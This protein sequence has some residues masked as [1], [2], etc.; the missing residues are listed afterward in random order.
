MNTELENVMDT[1]WSSSLER[2]MKKDIAPIRPLLGDFIDVY[3]PQIRTLLSMQ[4]NPAIAKVI[5]DTA[6]ASANRN[7]F[8]IMKKLGMPAD[9]FWKFEYWPRERAYE[10][11]RKV[12]NKVFWTM[13]NH[14]KEGGLELTAVE[15]E[16]VRFTIA[17]K[18]CAD[19]PA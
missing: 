18:D 7:T 6:Y 10:T 11:L 16:P 2:M 12:I 9:Y 15:I 3:V 19:P 17:F 8:V 14:N 5:Y 13:M 4:A 1:V